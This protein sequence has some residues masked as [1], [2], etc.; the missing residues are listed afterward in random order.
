MTAKITKFCKENL[1]RRAQ[2]RER[3]SSMKYEKVGK[4]ILYK[5]DRGQYGTI[6][7]SQ[8]ILWG[9]SNFTFA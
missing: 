1:S 2:E 8:G 9:P 3:N 6:F 7:L 5:K 4:K